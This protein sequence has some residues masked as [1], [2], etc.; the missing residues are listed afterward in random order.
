[1][2]RVQPTAALVL[3]QS[4]SGVRGPARLFAHHLALRIVGPDDLGNR[5]NERLVTI[6]M[7]AQR[8]RCI[9]APLNRFPFELGDAELA[10]CKLG[11]RVLD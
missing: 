5:Q 3:L 10:P 1:M 4:L 7:G 6:K 8:F 9:P 11:V 2:H